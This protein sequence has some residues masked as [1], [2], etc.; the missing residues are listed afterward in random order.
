MN[1]VL[2]MTLLILPLLVAVPVKADTQPQQ[3]AKQETV[4]ANVNGKSWE[5]A[6]QDFRAAWTKWK[7]AK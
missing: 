5:Q 6:Y 7:A 2:T 1:S 3:P 4:K